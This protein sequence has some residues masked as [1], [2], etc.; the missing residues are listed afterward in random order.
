MSDSLLIF[1]E[2]KL[3]FGMFP[4]EFE[5]YFP[6]NN[7]WISPEEG[8]PN[9]WRF[10]REKPPMRGKFVHFGSL[11]GKTPAYF[12]DTG[13][14]FMKNIPG[15]FSLGIF[16]GAVIL[17]IPVKKLRAKKIEIERESKRIPAQLP[18]TAFRYIQR[19]Q[20]KN[21]LIINPLLLFR[22]YKIIFNDPIVPV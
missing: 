8:K 12:D 17:R 7:V 2:N 9:I 13:Y 20:R 11:I 10:E 15:E 5:Q 6:L 14:I 22:A 16:I 1:Q 4:D 3:H 19:F 18:K 21:I